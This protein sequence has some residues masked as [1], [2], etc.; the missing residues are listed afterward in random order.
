[1][2]KRHDLSSVLTVRGFDFKASGN[3]QLINGLLKKGDFG[4]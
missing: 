3:L 4:F 2:A 1:L